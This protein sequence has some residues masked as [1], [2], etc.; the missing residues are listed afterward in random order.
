MA[1]FSLAAKTGALLQ[2]QLFEDLEFENQL[3]AIELNLKQHPE[4]YSLSTIG[5]VPDHLEYGCV[6][7]VQIFKIS[8]PPLESFVALRIK[9][10]K[11]FPLLNKEALLVRA[12]ISGL[13][14]LAVLDSRQTGVADR[15]YAAD[16]NDLWAIDLAKMNKGQPY[17]YQVARLTG[18]QP[19][20]N[21]LVVP[22]VEGR[23]V[24]L[25]FLSECATGKGLYMIQD[26]LSALSI[27]PEPRLI[28]AGD[29][30]TFFMRFGRLI[31][32][33]VDLVHQPKALDLPSH[34]T[35]MLRFDSVCQPDALFD[36]VDEDKLRR[37]AW[38][39]IKK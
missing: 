14:L 27:L 32:I 3:L 20:R 25:Y 17:C 31:L 36:C 1:R 8:A 38:R 37:L 21:L 18:M 30:Q 4:F 10:D 16:Q 2:K 22:D 7:G 19:L 13:S 29:Y 11:T 33:P 15:L 35:V 12:G 6:E 24:R 28:L 34:Q 39:K 23:G 26:T 9:Q 5:F